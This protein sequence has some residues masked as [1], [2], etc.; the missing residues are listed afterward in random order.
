MSETGPTWLGA[1][2]AAGRVAA[3]PSAAAVRAGDALVVPEETVGRLQ[4]G[5]A[6]TGV[7]CRAEVEVVI[8]QSVYMTVEFVVQVE[9]NYNA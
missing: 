7:V 3:P 4:L 1:R 8:N 5:R 6:E 2:P 9:V